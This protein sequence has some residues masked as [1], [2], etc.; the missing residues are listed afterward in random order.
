MRPML[1]ALVVAAVLLT[2]AFLFV[3]PAQD[4]NLSAPG[5]ASSTLRTAD[6]APTYYISLDFTTEPILPGYQDNMTY[7]VLNDTN[8]APVTQLSTITVTGT[9][10]NEG[11]HLLTFPG[12]PV[13]ITPPAPIGTWSFVVP[14]NAS[15]E[16]GFSPVFT[17]YANST[18]LAMNQ[19]EGAELEIGHLELFADVCNVV[20][21][22]GTLTVGNPATVYIEGII[23]GTFGDTGPAAGETVKI[24]FY[25]TGSSPVTV[26]GVPASV[27]TNSVGD[28]SVTFTPSSTIF[29]VPGPDKVSVHLED[30]VNGSVWANLTLNFRLVNPMGTTNFAFWLN[31]ADYYSG[32]TVTATWQWAGT[33]ATV[34]TLNITNYYVYDEETGN[35]IAN[36]LIY[37]SDPTGSFHF[38]LPA[39]YTGEID[40]EAYVYN[41]TD[42]W[43]LD[44]YAE[45]YLSIFAL[46]PSEHYFNPGDTITVAVTAEGPALAGATISAFVQA[47]NS[48]QTLYN[49]T[50]TGSSFQFTIP[51]VAP[52][53]EYDIAAWATTSTGAT[54]ASTETDVEEGTGYYTFWAGVTT[55]SSYADGSFAPGQTVQLSYKITPEGLSPV[56]VA[57]IIIVVY[58]GGCVAF[59][60]GPLA[61]VVVSGATGSVPFTIPSGTPN[62]L[63]TFF[64][65]S[66]FSSGEGAAQVSIDVNSAPSALNYELGAGSGLTVGWLILLILIIIVGIVLFAMMRRRGGK[67]STMVMSPAASSPSPEWK[68][69]Q[70]GGSMGGSTDAPAAPPGAQ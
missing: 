65:I 6:V 17:V 4:R 66:E 53:G 60:A 46:L 2:A 64:V 61:T 51:K 47:S 41:S 12:T 40:V 8:N 18:S 13:N 58:A 23:H 3:V 69:P 50:V 44:A 43:T 63:Q 28:A 26:P 27:V 30:S 24:L 20:G 16:T 5:A 68:E 10:Y 29:N 49:S 1:T 56:P 62:G 39:M 48:G 25:S 35:I 33:N 21:P 54:V 9:Y 32:A 37:S 52:A 70:S 22:C 59:C 36:G 19:S 14:A 7:E 31:Q 15:N 67:G 38:T 42:S 57:P 11:L 55:T 45:V 34:G